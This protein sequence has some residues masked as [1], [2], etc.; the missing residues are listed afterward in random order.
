[1]SEKTVLNRLTIIENYVKGIFCKVTTSLQSLTSLTQVLTPNLVTTP[2]VYEVVGGEV[3][4]YYNTPVSAF[5]TNSLNFTYPTLNLIYPNVGENL[6]T[7]SNFG[8]LTNFGSVTELTI[9][10]LESIVTPVTLSVPLGLIKLYL[11]DLKRWYS[12]AGTT[13]LGTSSN[14]TL[15]TV[16][17]PKLEFIGGSFSFDAT[18]PIISIDM[19]SLKVINGTLA[20]LN[21]A[22]QTLV[23]PEL[24]FGRFS[25]S[26]NSAIQSVNL[27][28]VKML[29][30]LTLAGPKSF[31]TSIQLP[32]IE[33]CGLITFPTTSASLTTFTFGSSLKFYGSSNT[34][35]NFV[36]TSN[37]L[38]QA[39]VD[40][41]LISLANLDGTNGTTAFSTRTVTITGTS[42]TPSAAGLVA[43]AT[44]VS[45]GCTVTTN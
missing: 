2:L 36:T 17:L 12:T 15:N 10:N 22:L 30:N 19:P 6:N 42:A 41:I 43:K 23:L 34:A 40:N 24:L 4:G 14:S 1:M 39:S 45:R 35:G 13:T 18:N 33:H 20:N 27:P 16:S 25:D 37:A 21:V 11:P 5:A 31:L 3:K 7:F 38:D 44:L 29:G 26:T 9:N 28:K 8:T 32:V